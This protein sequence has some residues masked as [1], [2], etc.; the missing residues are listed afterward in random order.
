MP[1]RSFFTLLGPLA[2]VTLII[3]TGIAVYFGAPM[4]KTYGATFVILLLAVL[5]FQ[6]FGDEREHARGYSK[7]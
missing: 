4:L 7:K 1:I 5:A 6:E 3:G 2:L